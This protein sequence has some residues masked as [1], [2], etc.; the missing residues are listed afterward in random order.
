M[1]DSR[2]LFVAKS[3]DDVALVF[4]SKASDNCQ[5]HSR[6]AEWNHNGFDWGKVAAIEVMA[7]QTT[8]DR[9]SVHS[10]CVTIFQS[11]TNRLSK[12]LQ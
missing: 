6:V 7:R 3:K 11:Q 2:S 4:F 8:N 1:S 10:G 9:F 5:R 12:I